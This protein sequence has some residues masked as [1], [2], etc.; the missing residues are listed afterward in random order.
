MFCLTH[1]QIHSGASASNATNDIFWFLI[2]CVGVTKLISA[3]QIICL[4]W[5]CAIEIEWPIASGYVAI[6]HII[7]FAF[8]DALK[9][10]KR[11]F[12]IS[13]HVKIVFPHTTRTQ[14]KAIGS[15][16]GTRCRHR[17]SN[18][19]TL[20][21]SSCVN[22]YAET[23]R[24]RSKCSCEFTLQWKRF[25]LFSEDAK[26]GQCFRHIVPSTKGFE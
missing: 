12:S 13:N 1:I 2:K 21:V 6:G 17:P 25:L 26:V 15:W 5:L 8:K 16:R 7:Q 14:L 24:A 23:D 20:F 4:F 10:T 19:C 11:L 9:R 3:M 18:R 22:R